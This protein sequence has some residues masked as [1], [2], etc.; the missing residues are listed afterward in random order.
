MITEAPAAYLIKPAKPRN[1]K[2]NKL[3]NAVPLIALMDVP[4]L[5]RELFER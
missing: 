1:I 4:S 3:Y 2:Q 5:S